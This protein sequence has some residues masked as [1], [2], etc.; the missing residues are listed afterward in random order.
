VAALE[1]SAALTRNPMTASIRS[2]AVVPDGVRWS[3]TGLHPSE[4]FWRQ[5]KFGDFDISEMSLAS[6]TIAASQGRRDWS[7]IPVFTTRKFFHAGIVVRDGAGIESP[8]DLAGKRIGVPEYQQTAAVWTRGALQHEFGVSPQQMTWFMER[9]PARSHGGS[10]SFRAPAGVDL[11]YMA[12]DQTMASMLAAGELDA[13]AYYIADRNLVDRTTTPSTAI[14]N[15]RPLFADPV[16][17]G[18]RYHAKTGLLPVNHTV[19]IRST[20]LDRHP[21]LALNVYSAF[22]EAKELALAPVLEVGGGD[23]LL[24]PWLQLGA[25]SATTAAAIRSTDPLPYGFTAQGGVLDALGEYLVEQGLVTRRI[26]ITELFA[27]STRDL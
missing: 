12:P 2:G 13:S 14:G 3:V 23:S 10:T 24:D 26:A 6:L 4:L 18:I 25:L 20:L 1:L 27:P 21:W 11:T 8:A 19:V 22:V 16:A 5:L 15:V 17:E 7:A 9:P